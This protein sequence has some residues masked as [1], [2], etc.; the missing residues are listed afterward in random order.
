MQGDELE[1][2]NFAAISPN[3]YRAVL[4][5]AEAGGFMEG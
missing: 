2:I 4:A 3:L 5:Q 1:S